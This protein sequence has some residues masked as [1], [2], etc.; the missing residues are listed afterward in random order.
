MRILEDGVYYVNVAEDILRNAKT[1]K[2]YS[3]YVTLWDRFKDLGVD[4]T[5]DIIFVKTV[6]PGENSVLVNYS[7]TSNERLVIY[8]KDIMSY[9][10]ISLKVSRDNA[11]DQ[12]NQL[13]EKV[14]KLETDLEN[15]KLY[16]S[17]RKASDAAFLSI[18]AAM[19]AGFS[20]DEA[21]KILLAS[22]QCNKEV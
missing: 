19:D 3:D 12:L 22:M 21:M 4:V 1:G 15:K 2:D 14:K 16:E 20:R 10:K 8:E 18:T 5:G 17:I 7:A 11:T 6:P 13:K 9:D